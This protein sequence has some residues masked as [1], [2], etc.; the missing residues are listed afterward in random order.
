MKLLRLIATFVMASSISAQGMSDTTVNIG[1][2]QVGANEKVCVVRYKVFRDAKCKVEINAKNLKNAKTS[3]KPL[4]DMQAYGKCHAAPLERFKNQ[5]FSGSFTF[6][7][8]KKKKTSTLQACSVGTGN[9]PSKG[10]KPIG[11]GYEY[12]NDFCYWNQQFQY[13]LIIKATETT[14]AEAAGAVIGGLVACCVCIAVLV[15]VSKKMCGG[16]AA[17]E[18][19]A[20]EQDVELS[21]PE[22]AHEQPPPP[23][24]APQ[25]G[26]PQPMYQQP[27]QPGVMQPN[28]MM[29][30]PG[31][32]QQPMMQQPGM[33]M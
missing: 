29:Q 13:G 28:P 4:I 31:M 24:A 25:M 30:Q 10:Q 21:K 22:A 19:G 3:D 12:K 17:V 14:P 5:F 6:R 2:V 7:S 33:M 8:C 1:G 18:E 27:M 11:Q 32:Y 20:G 23:Q 26:Q 9:K 16:K 15:F